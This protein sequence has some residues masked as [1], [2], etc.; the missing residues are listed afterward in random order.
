MSSFV[1]IFFVLINL[2]LANF[3]SARTFKEV[4]DCVTKIATDCNDGCATSLNSR[5]ADQMKKCFKD[6]FAKVETEQD[7]CYTVEGFSNYK[8]IQ[9]SPQN[10][11]QRAKRQSSSTDEIMQ[12]YG[13]CVAVC[14]LNKLGEMMACN[15]G[16]VAPVNEQFERASKKCSQQNTNAQKADNKDCIQKAVGLQIGRVNSSPMLKVFHCFYNFH[17]FDFDLL[18]LILLNK[19]FF[20]ILITTERRLYYELTKRCLAYIYTQYWDRYEYIRWENYYANSKFLN[21][22]D[23]T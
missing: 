2:Y 16:C 22:L 17:C 23:L 14:A 19:T 18:L 9:C 8:T 1:Q 20:A 12:N 10:I 7:K 4:S 11:I 13:R 5:A 3:I 21:I 6:V 15:Q